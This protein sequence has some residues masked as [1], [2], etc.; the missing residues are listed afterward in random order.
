MRILPGRSPT[1]FHYVMW[2]GV[3][4]WFIGLF[5]LFGYVLSQTWMRRWIGD[6]EMA[7]NTAVA[8]IFTGISIYILALIHVRRID[9]CKK[10]EDINKP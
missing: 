1:A 2:M 6:T 4:V 8:F 9:I 7:I 10:H 5:G 3:I